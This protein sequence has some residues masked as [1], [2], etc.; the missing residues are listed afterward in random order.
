MQ[1]VETARRNPY[2]PDNGVIGETERSRLSSCGSS[3]VPCSQLLQHGRPRP[4]PPECERR[5]PSSFH[6]TGSPS[7]APQMHL[8]TPALPTRPQGLVSP[9]ASEGS[10]TWRATISLID[11]GPAGC[12]RR[13]STRKPNE[14]Q[15]DE[16]LAPSTCFRFLSLPLSGTG[17]AINTACMILIRLLDDPL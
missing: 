10:S 11:P 2:A 17:D 9:C 6:Q 15:R 8:N 4:L 16:K 1:A 13:S 14:R 3:E 5:A 7:I 12:V